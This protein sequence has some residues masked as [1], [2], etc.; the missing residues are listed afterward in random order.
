M[1]L[2]LAFVL[3]AAACGSSKPAPKAPVAAAPPAPA[4]EPEPEPEPPPAPKLDGWY[5]SAEYSV[6]LNNDGTAVVE[7]RAKPKK[8]KVKATKA[9]TEAGTWDS[10]ASTLTVGAEPAPVSLE[11]ETLVVTIGGTEQRLA[12]QPIT[13]E[14]TTFTNA[15]GSLQL[16]ADGTC[17]HGK[18]GQPTPCAYK[19]EGGKLAISYPE[20]PKK[21]P[22]TWVVWFD[23]GG[24]VLHTPTETFTASAE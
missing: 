12:R 8:G 17:V 7:T 18:A 20:A 23:E 14:D 4:P 10:A 21:K 13:F 16:K 3:A 11:G 1:K 19:L 6:A 2:L 22:V 24:K 15:K 5:A 9:K